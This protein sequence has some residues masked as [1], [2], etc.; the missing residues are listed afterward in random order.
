M[1]FAAESPGAGTWAKARALCCAA[2][3][4]DFL[5][6]ACVRLDLGLCGKARKTSNLGFGV[7]AS[8]G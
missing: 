8:V 3:A 1:G 4:S 6:T 5:L 7:F 2:R